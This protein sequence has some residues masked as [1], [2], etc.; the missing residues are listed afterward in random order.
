M[1]GPRA[2]HLLCAKIA[3]L[4]CDHSPHPGLFN[5]NF[6]AARVSVTPAAAPGSGRDSVAAGCPLPATRSSVHA[7]AHRLSRQQLSPAP[8]EAGYRNTLTG[9]LKFEK[10]LQRVF[11]R[12]VLICGR[13][14]RGSKQ[15]MPQLPP[16]TLTT[17]LWSYW[18][19][20]FP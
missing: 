7:A 4:Y 3:L 8:W 16:E 1:S 12:C 9:G 5:Q 13:Q 2:S 11:S 14:E 19:F 15:E 18:Y 10:P 6:S 17:S 20:L